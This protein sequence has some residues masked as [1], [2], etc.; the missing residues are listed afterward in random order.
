MAFFWNMFQSDQI[1]RNNTIASEAQIK[2]R[3]HSGDLD[4]LEK[5]LDTLSLASQAM[6]EILQTKYGVS[7]QELML[8]MEEIDLR[9][10]TKDGKL[11][12]EYST[13]CPD[14][15]HK[16][17]KRRGSCYWCGS[18]LNDGNPFTS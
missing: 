1:N 15:G 12:P 14:C 3:S 6:W 9:D 16:V 13:D 8:K 11:N 2:T 5:R 18:R 4:H 7:E 10:G 17:K